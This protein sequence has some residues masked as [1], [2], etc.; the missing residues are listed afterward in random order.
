MNMLELKQEVYN[1]WAK[2]VGSYKD[3]V[4]QPETFKAEIR[5]Y[6]DL[7]YKLTWRKAFAAL[8]AQAHWYSGITEHTAIVYV[9]GDPSS[10]WD[11]ELRSLM[12]EYFLTIPGA[13]DFIVR[14]LEEIFQTNDEGDQECANGILAMVS[15]KSG[16]ISSKS[17]GYLWRLSV[18]NAS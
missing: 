7:R 11:L 4:V 10:I 17:D 18:A 15:S 5:A 9:F 8:E 2:L 16:G 3:A 12:L 13:K 14:G 1:S 6:G